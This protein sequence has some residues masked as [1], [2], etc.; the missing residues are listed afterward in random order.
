MLT[1][2]FGI[3]RAVVNERMYNVKSHTPG[4]QPKRPTE[5]ILYAM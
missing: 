5:Q 4:A 1:N 2:N 3:R